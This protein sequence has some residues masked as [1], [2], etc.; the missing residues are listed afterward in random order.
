MIEKISKQLV[1]LI[2]EQCKDENN[3][4][5]IKNTIIEPLIMHVLVQVQPFIVATMIYFVS[6]FIMII[7]LLIIVLYPNRV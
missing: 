3:K 5:V 7:I 1:E 2:I 6:T 4:R